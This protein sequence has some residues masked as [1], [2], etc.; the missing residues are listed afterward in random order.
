MMKMYFILILLS[1]VSVSSVLSAPAPYVASGVQTT[2]PYIGGNGVLKARTLWT[3][4][5]PN[6]IWDDRVLCM[7][8]QNKNQDDG[9]IDIDSMYTVIIKESNMQNGPLGHNA[10]DN[11]VK[12]TGLSTKV[13]NIVVYPNPANSYIIVSYQTKDNGVFTLYNSL[14][15]VVLKTEL[16]MQNTKTQIPI[17]EIANGLYHYE[18]EFATMIKTIGKLSIL[19]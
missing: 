6:A 15:E 12:Q 13:E 2:C 5:Q 1:V 4:W 11:N 18:V 7:Q 19:K 10:I 8:G 14:G 9:D 16:S 17:F 3:H